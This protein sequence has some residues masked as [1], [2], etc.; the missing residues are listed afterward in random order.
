MQSGAKEREKP[1]A[2]V[3]TGALDQM[4]PLYQDYYSVFPHILKKRSLVISCTPLWVFT[5]TFY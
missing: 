5:L 2:G 3:I 4:L 1:L